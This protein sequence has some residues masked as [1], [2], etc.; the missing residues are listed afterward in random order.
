MTATL[1]AFWDDLSFASLAQAE[2]FAD[3]I[4]SSGLKFNWSAAVRVDLFGDPKFDYSRR[5]MVAQKFKEAG[6][7]SLGFSLESANKEILE[8]MNK[9]I[10]GQY[11]L[12]QV[13][14]LDEVGITSM[15][16]VVLDILLKHEIQ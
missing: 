7:L 10:E 14:L 3:A 2:R 4:I 13:K 6:C 15:I 8:M 12:D 16:S 5:L 9:R 11:F 1:L